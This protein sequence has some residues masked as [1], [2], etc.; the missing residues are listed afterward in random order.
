MLSTSFTNPG[1]NETT[2]Y[3]PTTENFT[4]DSTPDVWVY[5]ELN[6]DIGITIANCSLWLNETSDTYGG[7]I[8]NQT[9]YNITDH[10]FVKLTLPTL[11]EGVNN[12]WWVHCR[13]T[14]YAWSANSTNLSIIYDA[15]APYNITLEWPTNNTNVSS[16]PPLKFN[17][18]DALD[19]G[20]LRCNLTLDDGTS[21]LVNKTNIASANGTSITQAPDALPAGTY[22][23]N[24]SCWDRANNLQLGYVGPHSEA[25]KYGYFTVGTAAPVVGIAFSPSSGILVG[26]DVTVTC[27][28]TDGDYIKNISI[29]GPGTWG[30]TCSPGSNSTTGSCSKVYTVTTTGTKAFDCTAYDWSFAKTDATQTSFT[31]SASG[32][33]GGGAAGGLTFWDVLDTVNNYYG[34]TL[35]FWALLDRIDEYYA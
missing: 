22:K 12:S 8:Y 11:L 6:S 30:Q 10:S 18:S 24:V 28:S 32:G 17:V 5:H 20:T 21:V 33:G 29:T 19:Y 23:W 9:V 34:G 15:T 25:L 31:V 16:T 14:T 7:A 1:V 35:D 3:A 27:S 4:G 26:Y 13:N 2:T